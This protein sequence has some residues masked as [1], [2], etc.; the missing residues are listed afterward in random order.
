MKG[1]DLRYPIGEFSSK[2]QI[3]IADRAE[4]IREIDEAPR[5]LRE[6]VAGLSANQLETPYREGGWTVRQV[7]HHLPDSHLNAYIRCRLALTEH[8]PTIKPYEQQLWAE[9]HDA[10]TSPVEVSLALLESLH[11]RWIVLLKSLSPDD[12]ARTF[13]HP[14]NGT[15]NLDW[16]LQMYAW[17]GRHHTAQIASLRE[18][19]GW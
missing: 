16:L 4:L 2:R 11:Q 18:R 3:T 5:R 13:I 6:A 8:N 14:E 1:K 17:H 10:R 12:F 19:M 9:L 15:Q 7:V